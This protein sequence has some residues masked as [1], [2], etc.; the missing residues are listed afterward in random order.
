MMSDMEVRQVEAVKTGTPLYFYNARSERLPL[1]TVSIERYDQ[2]RVATYNFTPDASNGMTGHKRS[3]ST[4]R[5]GVGTG[6]L[7]MIDPAEVQ[8][9]FL[10]QGWEIEKQVYTRGGAGLRTIFSNPTHVWDDV[11]DYDYRLWPDRPQ[12]P[13]RLSVMVESNI[14]LSYLAL[15]VVEGL[16][17]KVCTNGA[18]SVLLHLGGYSAKHIRQGTNLYNTV[19]TN[20]AV[21]DKLPGQDVQMNKTNL[22]QVIYYLDRS[23]NRLLENGSEYTKKQ[24]LTL[25]QLAPFRPC[26]MNKSMFFAFMDATRAI[27]DKPGD[28]V[29]SLDLINAYTNGINLSDSTP[30]DTW[31]AY[32][33]VDTTLRA[34]IQLAN[35]TEFF[36]GSYHPTPIEPDQPEPVLDPVGPENTYEDDLDEDTWNLDSY[37]SSKK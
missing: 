21:P 26:T 29:T 31:N 7:D 33:N 12:A 16:Y 32:G 13:L 34:M 25:T 9:V 15:R 14:N 28:A 1:G 10:D 3:R 30:T 2:D 23:Y 35:F 19:L 4:Y 5:L 11:I 36:D 27:L 22:A 18:Y 17:R 24:E 20:M 37:L 8:K 6:K